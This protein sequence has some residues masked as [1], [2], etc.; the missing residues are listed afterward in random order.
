[1]HRTLVNAVLAT[2]LAGSA[3]RAEP[4]ASPPKPDPAGDPALN[5]PSIQ[6]AL[7]EQLRRRHADKP[8]RPAQPAR[9]AK[10]VPV[11][12][13]PSLPAIPVVPGGEALSFELAGRK[14]YPEGTFLVAR[15][16]GVVR[17][18]TDDFLFLAAPANGADE[19][20]PREAPMILLPSQKLQLLASAMSERSSAPLTTIS[21]Q[22][23]VYS[24]RMYLLVTAFAFTSSAPAPAPAPVTEASDPR[25]ED[26][27]RQ[28]EAAKG[29]PRLIDPSSVGGKRF[30]A[31]DNIKGEK[32]EGVLAEGTVLSS[33]RGRLV[34]A[35]AEGELLLTFD[36]DPDSPGA[37]SMPLLP[38]KLLQQLEQAA[39]VRGE[40]VEFRVTG[41]VTV[42]HGRN[43]LLPIWFQAVRPGDLRP[44]Q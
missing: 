37:A 14:F 16:G 3:V 18:S 11:V 20:Q 4:P 27:I 7:D 17:T 42:Y 1:M 43:Y 21:G 8:L 31:R 38:C 44:M 30:S 36:N 35:A 12:A 32:K 34:R 26:L 29:G 24:D 13:P 6:E 2:L 10:S 28:L 22:V 39:S 33:R 5:D 25:A 40:E 19:G 23:F 15:V 41:R 9:E